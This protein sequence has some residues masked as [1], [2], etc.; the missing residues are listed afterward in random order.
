VPPAAIPNVGD[1]PAPRPSHG[2]NLI[3]RLLGAT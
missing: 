2:R 3:E 1:A